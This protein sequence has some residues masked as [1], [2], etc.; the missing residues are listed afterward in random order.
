MKK[1]LLLI[2][3]LTIW[4]LPQSPE[5]L[6]GTASFVY[7]PNQLTITADDRSVLHWQE[8]SIAENETTRF[9]LP[10]IHSAILNRVMSATPSQ[11]MGRLESNG[12]V[13]LINPNGVLVGKEAMIDVGSLIASTL[14]ISS[15]QKD[16][17]IFAG[18]SDASV[19]NL[20]TIMAQ[21]GD[22]LLIAN[23][24]VNEGSIE[25]GSAGL[26]AGSE[27]IL[28]PAGMDRLYV[29]GRDFSEAFTHDS[30]VDALE[31]EDGVLMATNKGSIRA[32]DS[33]YVLGEKVLL[34]QDSRIDASGDFGGGTV[35]IGGDYQGKNGAIANAKYT[36][37][38][39]GSVINAS[40]KQ[41]GN[42]GKVIVWADK[43]TGFYGEVFAQGGSLGG[44]GGFVEVSGDMLQ[45]AGLVNTMAPL[46]KAGT[47]LLDPCAVTISTAVDSGFAVP[48]TFTGA[49]A[50][51]NNTNL[52]NNL[53]AGS[54]TI[55]ASLGTAVTGSITVLAGADVGVTTLWTFSS[56]LTLSTVGAAGPITINASIQ[57]SANAVG[58]VTLNAPTGQTIT[59]DTPAAAGVATAVGSQNGITAIGSACSPNRPDVTVINHNA[60][61][62]ITTRLGF[63]GSTASGAI[64]V[65]C[66]HLTV[67]GNTSNAVIGHGSQVGP[68]TI[69]GIITV[70]ASGPIDL[71]NRTPAQLLAGIGH[72]DKRFSAQSTSTLKGDIC[73]S[74]QGNINMQYPPGT[75]SNVLRIGHGNVVSG[76]GGGP[77]PLLQGNI[78]VY[79]GG[80]IELNSL[81]G[82][83]TMIGHYQGSV[84]SQNTSIGD[85]YV[86]AAGNIDLTCVGQTDAIIGHFS[87]G[88]FAG[89]NL[90]N[91]TSNVCVIAGGYINI[92]AGALQAFCGI[93][94]FATNLVG[95]VS[96]F[97]GTDNIATGAALFL[98][99]SSTTL[100]NL[101]YVGHIQPVA[102]GTSNTFVGV[103]GDLKIQGTAKS[104]IQS[105]ANINVGVTGNITSTASKG[106]ISTIDNNSAFT[107]QIW[108]GAAI[109][110]N[111]T[112]FYGFNVLGQIS[113]IDIRAGSNVV[114]PYAISTSTGSV[115]IQTTT[116]FPP[117]QLWTTAGSVRNN[118]LM[119]A[120]SLG[121]F[122]PTF[123][124]CA[125]ESCFLPPIF[126]PTASLQNVQ[127][128]VSNTFPTSITTTTG[129]I[130]VGANNNNNANCI[131][132][133]ACCLSFTDLPSD[134]FLGA[135]G[136]P[137]T[138]ISTVSGNIVV[139]G[140]RDIVNNLP[141]TTASSIQLDAWRNININAKVIAG[142]FCYTFAGGN[143][144]VAPGV[145]VKAQDELLMISGLSMSIGANATLQS[146]TQ[147]LT[148][149][150]DNQFPCPLPPFCTSAS[151]GCCARPLFG[152]NTKFTVGAGAALSAATGLRIF[153]SLQNNTMISP[154]ATL[155]TALNFTPGPT[156]FAN[157]N[158][159][160]WCTYYPGVCGASN[161]G[162]FFVNPNPPNFTIFY[163]NCMQQATSQATVVITEFLLDLHPY[164]EFPGW[165]GEFW[166]KYLASESLEDKIVSSRDSLRKEPYY[167]RRRHLNI[168]NHPKTWTHLEAESPLDTWP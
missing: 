129:N 154:S 65:T 150:I 116:L 97:A 21:D 108:A 80:N 53:N 26:I 164:N 20:G 143:T 1:F 111:G 10:T 115:N 35:L 134:I 17:W 136:P 130:N 43:G 85:I 72:G 13:L 162:G 74:A 146:V 27:V 128:F 127:V 61:N 121:T 9:Q 105:S 54:V 44:D 83:D 22:V 32:T 99:N 3:P 40:A 25:N 79:S 30:E 51:V 87:N 119:S 2:C 66:G 113:N 48:Y 135:G 6:N 140:F 168:I 147:D 160:V 91:V 137:G 138:V 156:P 18:S 46:G 93:G 107:T 16:D 123:A 36:W 39:P 109:T 151:P 152:T 58:G 23:T 33:V 78:S 112:F 52:V 28:K 166:V 158:Q 56:T 57:H 148:L 82:A 114:L 165:M 122:A 98:N 88:A 106:H 101:A 67:N 71:Q 64:N 34:T 5:L 149:V 102:N 69:S 42:G 45:F 11:I 38:E 139:S 96:V 110:T 55:D 145:T 94:S 81:S 60:A 155:N 47:L 4:A 142:T 86:A 50:N 92:N 62:T 117:G 153:S 120:C 161:V 75:G 73:V 77:I 103:G 37:A 95:S 126:A 100:P 89:A 31:F 63:L 133:S 41:Q 29:R 68:L 167:L 118:L 141:L 131:P 15:F 159:E 104:V 132:G 144:D 14:D 76:A 7:A 90:T 124:N 59:I 163:K 84:V 12:Q 157:T 24:V 49:V 8:F 19:I 70:D 125:F